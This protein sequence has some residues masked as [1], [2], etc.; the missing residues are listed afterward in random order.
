MK[1]VWNEPFRKENR[2]YPNGTWW[3]KPIMGWL[4]YN[5]VW[6]HDEDIEIDY[7]YC[8]HSFCITI[9]ECHKPF[10]GP[11]DLQIQNMIRYLKSTRLG[12]KITGTW[13]W[14][15]DNRINGVRFWIFAED[16]VELEKK[17]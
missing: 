6:P 10:N 16:K 5:D 2:D 14:E 3:W 12:W 7:N 11:P 1:F 8:Y 9:F 15:G 17:R 13:R 4:I